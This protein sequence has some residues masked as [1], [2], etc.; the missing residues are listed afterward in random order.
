MT[1]LNPEQIAQL[2]NDENVQATIEANKVQVAKDRDTELML[3]GYNQALLDCGQADLPEGWTTA[4]L[5]EV[6]RKQRDKLGI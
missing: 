4:D 2:T 3:L 5:Q 6:I 1:E